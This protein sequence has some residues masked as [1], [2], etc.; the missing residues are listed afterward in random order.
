LNWTVSKE[1]AK[2]TKG[3]F[4]MSV[5]SMK[6]KDIIIS[7]KYED[8]INVIKARI[9]YKE[10]VQSL[11]FAITLTESYIAEILLIILIAYPKKILISHKGNESQVYS[12]EL[13]G[14]AVL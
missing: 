13:K 7:R 12:M 9:E 4:E 1:A 14:S 8:I 10:F 6:G 11:I 3:R 2:K 5:P